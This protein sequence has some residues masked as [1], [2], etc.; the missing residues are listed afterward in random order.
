MVTCQAPSNGL[1]R[2]LAIPCRIRAAGTA[3]SRDCLLAPDRRRPVIRAVS[4]WGGGS[5]KAYGQHLIP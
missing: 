4:G 5:L 3:S 1:R 2:C